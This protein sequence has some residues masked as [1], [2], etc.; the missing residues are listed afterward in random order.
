MPNGVTGPAEARAA[1][2]AARGD[3]CCA[4]KAPNR[5]R[6]PRRARL[7]SVR[8]LRSATAGANRRVL[9]RLPARAAR[10]HGPRRPDRGL[11]TAVVQAA[12]R[13]WAH[14]HCRP[15]YTP[16]PLWKPRFIPWQSLFI[17]L[18]LVGIH[19]PSKV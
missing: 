19:V 11:L 12:Y 10:R 9:L 15:A 5:A 7:A 13:C 3:R 17:M 6:L 4:A 8:K 16:T 2:R 1:E 18:Q 14:Q